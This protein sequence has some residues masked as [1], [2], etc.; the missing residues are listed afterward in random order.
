MVREAPRGLD[1]ARGLALVGRDDV[2]ALEEI[3]H[4]A[5][6]AAGEGVAGVRV[7][8][9]EAARHAVVVE[10]LVDRVGG[11]HAGQREVAAG[12][13]FRQA[14]QVGR[15]PRLLAG[16]HRPR[17]P[18][19]RHDLVGD[20]EHVVAGAER[21]GAPQVLG[22]VE[23]HAGRALRQ[24][25]DNERGNLRVPLVEE[26]LER[27][28]RDFRAADPGVLVVVGVARGK[29]RHQARVEERRIGV[30]EDRDIGDAQRA[31][32][33]AVIAALQGGEARLSGLSPVCPVAKRHL[34]RDL[35]G[36]RAIGCEE[37]VAELARRNPGE[38]LGELHHG[39]VGESREHHVLQGL[40]LAGDRRVDRRVRMPEEVHP[41]GAHPVEVAPAVEVV[42]PRSLRALDRDQRVALVLLHLRARMPDRGPA[43][44]HHVAVAHAR[45]SSGRCD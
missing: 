2:A 14:E 33:L 41:P 34:Q 5:G 45:P 21:A 40:D 17:A 16:E 7:R 10:R 11:Q 15:D 22:V 26:A 18:E 9:E 4:R 31:H 27:G 39:L 24:R 37:G 36:G 12:E 38:P 13:S 28:G 1:E 42:Q 19:S 25:L 6:R 44:R 23:A 35:G 29:G 43:T 30:A 8:V 20:E 32:G 3:Q